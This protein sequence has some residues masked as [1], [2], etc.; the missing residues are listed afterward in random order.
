MN[1]ED[2]TPCQGHGEDPKYFVSHCED[3]TIEANKYCRDCGARGVVLF[4]AI[5]DTG[6][7]LQQRKEFYCTVPYYCGDHLKSHA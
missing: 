4:G 7:T 6:L 3:C 5:H 2:Y 1:C